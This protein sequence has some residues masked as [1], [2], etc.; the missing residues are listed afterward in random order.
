MVFS[1]VV[2][3]ASGHFENASTITKRH[4]ASKRTHEVKVNS[5]K[6]Q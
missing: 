4:G 3:F 6:Y 2:F 5:L 1:T